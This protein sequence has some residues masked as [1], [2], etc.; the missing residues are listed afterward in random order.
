M[1]RKQ[2]PPLD[3]NRVYHI[4]VYECVPVEP[5]SDPMKRWLCYVK[6]SPRASGVLHILDWRLLTD[7][8]QPITLR[9]AAAL[10]GVDTL[11][12]RMTRRVTPGQL[13]LGLAA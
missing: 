1:N 11:R 5:L 3:T 4:G 12:K 6:F 7:R 13:P 10:F 9:Q 2:K 8:P